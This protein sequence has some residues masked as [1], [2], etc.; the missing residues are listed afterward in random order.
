MKIYVARDYRGGNIKMHSKKF[1]KIQFKVL[2]RK[3]KYC[4]FVTIFAQLSRCR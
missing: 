1:W 4:I 2:T 3:E